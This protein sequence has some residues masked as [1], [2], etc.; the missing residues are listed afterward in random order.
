MTLGEKVKALREQRGWSQ[1]E[2]S[3]RAKVRQSLLSALELNKQTDTTGAV[4]RR[5]ATTL[6]VSM[7]YLGGVY[8][9]LP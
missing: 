8:D 5:L 4:L 1:R 2:L 3:R 9:R 6:G 7:D